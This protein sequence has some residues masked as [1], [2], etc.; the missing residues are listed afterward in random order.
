[1][2]P[3]EPHQGGLATRMLVLA[4]VGFAI[5]F[6]AWALLSPLAPR[7]KDLLSLSG[8]QQ[9]LLVAVPVIVGS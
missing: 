5:N 4:T 2:T 1:M 9:A 7:L 8:G 6:W 3:E